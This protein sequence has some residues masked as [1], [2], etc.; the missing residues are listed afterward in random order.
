MLRTQIFVGKKNSMLN[1]SIIPR[2]NPTIFRQLSEHKVLSLS[3]MLN[4]MCL[5]VLLTFPAN[6]NSWHLAS[7]WKQWQQI[8][9][10]FT[11]TSEE[12]IFMIPLTK[13]CEVLGSEQ[14]LWPSCS[15]ISNSFA[16]LSSVTIVVAAFS[17]KPEVDESLGGGSAPWISSNFSSNW[18]WVWP[19]ERERS[20][21]QLHKFLSDQ[22]VS[23]LLEW[24]FGLTIFIK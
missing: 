7:F 15:C 19:R 5:Q 9:R 24:R 3:I 4:C 8:E 10:E 11:L 22:L 2:S 20:E 17:L 14:I 13:S 21:S 12:T 16:L 6:K 23:T 18:L 1:Q